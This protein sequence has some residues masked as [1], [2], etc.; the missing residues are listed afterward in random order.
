M[1]E[2]TVM[3]IVRV[4]VLAAGDDGGRLT[5]MALPSELPLR[6]IL[7][8]VQRIVQPARENDG[9]A[10]PA[11]APN[12]VRLSLAPIGGAPFS[13]DATLDTVGVVDG[14]LLALQAVP[15]GPPAPRIVEDIA[16]AAVIFSEARRR[17]WGPTHIARG[18]ALA[19]IGLI[20]VGTGLSV[21][22]RVITGDLLGQFIVSGI[23]LATVIAALAVRNR[24]AVL[25]TSLAVTALVPVAAAFA[26]GVPGDFGAPNVLLAAAGVAAWSL[27]SMAGSPD[28]RGIAVF[29]ATAVT[30][31]GVLLVAGAASLW[32]ISSD[33]IGC[34]LVLL[35]LIVTV[36][37]AQLSAMW[38]RFPLPVI[39]APGDPTPAARPLSVLADLPRRVRVSQAHQTGVIAAGVL[40]GVAG[41]VALV[42]SANASPWAW[43]IVVAAA[44]GAAL[45]ARV[46]D[47]AACKAWLLG[48]SYLLA[49]ALLV[50]FVIGDRYQ[51]ALWALA[52]LAVLVLVWIV[53]AL[54]PKIASPDTYSL[55]MRRM[56]GFLATGLDASLIPV[57]ALLVGLFSLVLDR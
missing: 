10:D 38:A 12:P 51:A 14:D 57:M 48:H 35:G 53:A 56:V 8:A 37:A 27:I 52:A 41:S 6:E 4:A 54:N 36:Q 32:V 47:S 15:S 43:Y 11:A 22:H 29:T 16:D 49:V 30:G 25:A 23:A 24:S 9:A 46:W 1:S 7:P 20:L 42:S 40:L 31:V 28:D 5:E 44:A 26:L 50:A 13:L 21:A 18:A 55:P 19:L 3:P 34:A 17:Q 2:N 33:V 45:R 39:P